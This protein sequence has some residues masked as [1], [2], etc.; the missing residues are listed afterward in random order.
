MDA[1]TKIHNYCLEDI[2]SDSFSRYSKYIIQDRA[3]PDVRDGLKPVQRRILYSMYNNN[4][5]YDRPTVKSARAV[6]DI[7]GKYHPH[8]DSS[9]YDALVRMSQSWKFNHPLINMQGNNGSMDGDNAA[10]SRYTETRL[11]KIASELLKDIT[12]N[13]VA[14]TPTY[15]DTSTEPTVL[16]AKFPNLLVSGATGISAGYATNIPP[17]NLSELIDACVLLL[18]KENVTL[19]QLMKLVKGPDFP[20]GGTCMDIEGIK[21]AFETGR[22]RVYVRANYDIVEL[23]NM[24]QIVI[25]EVPYEIN[26]PGLVRKIDEIR[27]DKKIDGILEVRDESDREGLRIVIDIKKDADTKFIA[28]YLLKN[29]D[30]MISYNYNMVAI[31]D[32]RP[33]LLGLKEILEAYLEHLREV[34]VNR[35]KFDLEFAKKKHHITLGLIKALSILDEVIKTIRSSKNKADARDNLVINYGFSKEQAESIVM[36]QLYRLT[37]TDILELQNEN[38]TLEEIINHLTSILGDES[39][40]TTVVVNELKRIKKEYGIERKTLIEDEY[41]EIKID[42]VKTIAKEEFIL[43]IT[44]EGYVKRISK[45]GYAANTGTLTGLKDLDYVIYEKEVS[46]LDTIL[47]FTNQGN[48]LY[49]NAYNVPECK[50]KDLGK[51]INNIIEI[52][53]NET[54]VTCFVFD[55]LENG[56]ITLFTKLG[57][58][59]RTLLSEFNATRVSKAIKCMKLKDEDEVIY[60]TDSLDEDV[61]LA[62]HNGYGLWF[63]RGEISLISKTAAGV[64][65]INLKDDLLASC[66]TISNDTKY[67]TVFTSTSNCKNIKITDLEKTSRAKKGVIILK[68][69]KSN[70]AKVI[71]VLATSYNDTLN[72]ITNDEIIEKPISDIKVYDRYSNGSNITKSI[73]KD[74]FI[75]EEMSIK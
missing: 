44:K 74:V 61:F 46:T 40:M 43:I 69:V 32:R 66:T 35:S 49:L 10:A 72:I 16:P 7:M 26:K 51:H 60:V 22:G 73:I 64:K 21:S 34:I 4:N 39:L 17:H 33:K 24:N 6:G 2:M 41:K 52:N 57:M 31:V 45:K 9:I 36:L 67:I 65:A 3:I 75:K 42:V 62:T 71:K 29:T 47:L 12:K 5:V 56:E 48:Y 20:T 8:G 68:E 15:D 63:E 37:N 28:K 55:S 58:C 59:K 25:N 54:I 27:I 70:P 18:T 50:Y 38:N 11:S 14:F 13:T 30:M 53:S 23:K 1:L 19:E